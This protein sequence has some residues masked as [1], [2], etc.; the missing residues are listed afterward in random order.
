MGNIRT[1]ALVAAPAA[2]SWWPV[3]PVG[4]TGGTRLA[5]RIGRAMTIFVIRNSGK[6]MLHRT[7]ARDGQRPPPDLGRHGA[8]AGRPDWPTGPACRFRAPV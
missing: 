8:P 5:P 4:G 6:A 3:R 1:F 7:G 2:C